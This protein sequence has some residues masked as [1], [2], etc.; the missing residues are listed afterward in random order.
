MQGEIVARNYAEAL[1]EL[2]EKHG[3]LEEFG[4]GLAEI[5]RVLDEVPEFRLFLDTPRVEKEEKKRVLRER[6][7]GRVPDL[8]LNFVL[9]TVDRRRQRLLRQMNREYRAL[10]DEKLGRAHVEV[11]LAHEPDARTLEAVTARLSSVL[12]KQ[13]VPHVRVNPELLGGVVFRSGDTVFDGSVRRRLEQMK[14][15]LLAAEVSTG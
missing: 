15:R 2:G 7:E 3:R 8:V 1:F 6:L 5:A 4:A 14:R 13:V 11:T 12:G 10:L 9:L